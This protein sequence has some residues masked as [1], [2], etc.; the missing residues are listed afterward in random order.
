MIFSELD[1]IYI[2]S[3]GKRFVNE[4]EALRHE[5]RKTSGT[6]KI[7]HRL[8]YGNTGRPTSAKTS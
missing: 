5:A 1:F 6:M 2:T 3:D 8:R 7:E 4:D